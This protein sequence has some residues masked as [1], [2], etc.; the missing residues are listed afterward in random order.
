YNNPASR[1]ILDRWMDL[2]NRYM[3]IMV[4]ALK[5][6]SPFNPNDYKKETTWEKAIAARAFDTLRCLLPVGT[7]TLLS[8]HTN[9]RQ[10]RDHLRHL[11]SHPL[12]EVRTVA[13]TIFAAVTEK[14]PNSFNGEELSD[15][16]QRY[17]ARN[18]YAAAV[19]RESHYLEVDKALG[20]LTA[21]Q[22]QAMRNGDV[23]LYDAMFDTRMCN[24]A[25]EKLFSTRP[26]SAPLPRYL[27][28]YGL[29]K[30]SFLLDFGSYRDLQRHRNGICQI[31]VVGNQ[32]G[33]FEWYRQELEDLLTPADYQNLWRDIQ[34]Q[35]QAIADLPKKG[36][37]TDSIQ[38]QYLYPMG[39]ACLTQLTYSL[40][41][42]VYVAELRSQKTVH[43]SLRPIAQGMAREIQQRHPALKL[44]VDYDADSWTA[45]RGE[46]D[47]VEKKK[48]A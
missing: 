29:Y 19:A 30:F 12:E 6:R 41:Q 3:P 45:K 16:S 38:D 35:L 28:D 24:L 2:Y 40:P 4:E 46:Q 31:P 15:T 44:Y 37:A 47:I 8:W 27:C 21:Q 32:F 5:R 43:P 42:T 18:Q 25:E 36:I 33:F 10:L 7:T 11:Y 34:A 20:R 17:D 13:K 9:L 1:A 23:L 39:M 22:Q 14:Y 48:T 26:R